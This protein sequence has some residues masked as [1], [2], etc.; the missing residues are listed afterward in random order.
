[1]SDKKYVDK[2]LNGIGLI[3]I[4]ITHVELAKV[5]CSNDP[6]LETNLVFK[7]EYLTSKGFAAINTLKF[8][9]IDDTIQVFANNGPHKAYFRMSKEQVKELKEWL[10]SF[11]E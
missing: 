5:Y 1:M 2:L 11:E 7:Q 6:P 3:G 4:G 8:K 9:P 10:N